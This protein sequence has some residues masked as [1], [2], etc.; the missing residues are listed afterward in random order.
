M[1]ITWLGR[2]C[3]RM[4]SRNIILI[5]DP[6]ESNEGASI[7]PTSAHIVTMSNE[8]SDHSNTSSI[9]GNPRILEGPGEYEIAHYYITG[10]GTPLGNEEEGNINTIY[11][12]RAE[13]LV[14]CYIG[15]LST[16]LP[17]A[18]LDLLSQTQVLIAPINHSNKDIDQIIQQLTQTIQPRIFLPLTQP[19]ENNDQVNTPIASAVV[20]PTIPPQN[21]LNISET[22]LPGETRTVLLNPRP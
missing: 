16:K 1:E 12:I 7:V 14:L 22:N 11:I 2:S 17:P 4:D 9:I 5:T 3:I 15:N 18:Q 10:V 20:D 8:L 13:G 6:Y 19:F 21:R